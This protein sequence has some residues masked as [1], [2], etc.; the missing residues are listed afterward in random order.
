M[1]G[2]FKKL[3]KPRS[4][5]QD[6]DA[7][8]ERI[9]MFMHSCKMHV[10]QRDLMV[11]RKYTLFYVYALGAV[12]AALEEQG[13]D[14]TTAYAVLLKVIPRTSQLSPSDISSML[15]KCMQ[16]RSTPSGD[17]FLRNGHSHYQSWLNKQADVS[18]KLSEL[19]VK[20]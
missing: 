9:T 13:G 19:L 11:P 20:E 5:E 2:F 8:A 18:R 1:S 7:V 15:G 10:E 4:Q 3:F 17:N 12:L 6:I 14:E 16:E